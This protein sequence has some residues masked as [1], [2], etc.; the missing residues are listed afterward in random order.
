MDGVCCFAW[1][2][3]LEAW[4]ACSRLVYDGTWAGLDLHPRCRHIR[5]S[6]LAPIRVLARYCV[7]LS[8][9]LCSYIE[10]WHVR[11]VFTLRLDMHASAQL[12]DNPGSGWLIRHRVK[13]RDYPFEWG[14]L[15]INTV[16]AQA[17]G[18]PRW[19]L[20]ETKRIGFV[21]L[22]IQL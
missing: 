15:S 21:V 2:L 6:L 11:L 22:P 12:D 4:V 5:R 18:H 16:V 17:L 9:L 7:S 13:Q 8:T 19:C 1:S 20:T 10:A 3:K 14:T